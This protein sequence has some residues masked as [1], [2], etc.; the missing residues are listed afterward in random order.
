MSEMKRSN[1]IEGPRACAICGNNRR[2]DRNEYLIDQSI[3]RLTLLFLDSWCS[4]MPI[5]A[6]LLDRER[7]AR[8]WLGGY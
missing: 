5:N 4:T 6:P 3:T 7:L 2:T 8:R 1:Q